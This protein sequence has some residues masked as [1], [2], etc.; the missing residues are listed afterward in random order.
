MISFIVLTFIFVLACSAASKPNIV[1]I[2]VDDMGWSDAGFRN[3]NEIHTPSMDGFAKDGIILNRYYAQDVCSPTRASILSG[4]Y[5]SHLGL[6]HYV[7]NPSEPHGL[8]LN[9][10][11]LPSLLKEQGYETHAVGKWHQGFWKWDY[12]PTFRGFDSFYGFYNGGQTYFDHMNGNGYDMRRDNGPRCGKNCSIVDFNAKD[13]YST[14]LFTSEAI[15]VINNH[16]STNPMYLYLAYQAV[17]APD[18]VPEQYVK[19]YAETIKN[20]KR[21]AFAGM[22]TALDEGIYNVTEAL[23][24]K[25]LY[26]N[27]LLIFTSDNGGP[28]YEK[29]CYIC[30]DN[31]GSLNYPLRGGKHTLY[32]GGVRVTGMVTGGVIQDKDKDWLPTLL[33]ASGASIYTDKTN[34]VTHVKTSNKD[35]VLPLDGVSQWNNIIKK[36]VSDRDTILLNFDPIHNDGPQAGIIYKSHKLLLGPAGCPDIWQDK[37]QQPIPAPDM[38]ASIYIYINNNNNIEATTDIEKSLLKELG[39][40]EESKVLLFDIYN[41]ENEQIDIHEQFPDIVEELLRKLID[42]KSSLVQP[43]TPW[44]DPKADPKKYNNI[45][46][47]WG[48]EEEL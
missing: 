42:Y 38:N 13:I 23:K 11:T 26:E 30:G 36:Q 19:P 48:D 40:P 24:K 7:I 35:H 45:W 41:D 39:F 10:T 5:P 15:N 21:R 4:R 37:N 47:P 32:E 6:Q 14:T 17:H 29:D 3:D 44:N 20:Q 8:P 25:G 43:Y 34:H 31:A 18:E 16:N 12:T 28:I 9:E 27:T 22:M 46:V 1:F 2:I 33:E